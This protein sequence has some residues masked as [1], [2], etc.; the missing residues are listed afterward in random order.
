M[1]SLNNTAFGDKTPC[2]PLKESRH[3]EATFCL[4]IQDLRIRQARNQREGD[5]KRSSPKLHLTFSALLGVISQK[6]EVSVAIA[7]RT[8]NPPH[9]GD[10]FFFSTSKVLCN[11]VPVTV[12]NLFSRSHVPLSWMPA[13]ASGTQSV[14]WGTLPGG[15][16]SETV[17]ARVKRFRELYF[18]ITNKN[19]E[20]LKHITLD[21]VIN[22]IP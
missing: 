9:W 13:A 2:S 1:R 8:W 7:V 5:G 16:I 19:T 17:L 11:W 14:I 12:F 21:S 20:I 15:T 6:I 18:P 3:F 10:C 4:D 22:F